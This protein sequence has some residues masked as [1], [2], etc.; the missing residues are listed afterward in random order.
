MTSQEMLADRRRNMEEDYFRRQELESIARLR[1][2]AAR[3][4]ERRK[5]GEQLDLSDDEML[6][7]LQQ[8]G[9]TS[10]TSALLFLAPLVQVAWAEGRVSSSERELILE[11]AA[12]Q[13]IGPG[14]EAYL[15]LLEW[16]SERPS[17]ELME[18]SLRLIGRMLHQMSPDER[19][20]RKY[21]LLLFAT[22]VAEASGGVMG[23]VG[24]G[25]RICREEEA[26]LERIV[27]AIDE[28]PPVTVQG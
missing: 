7:A 6:L 9:Y 12:T 18:G 1:E 24:L 14:S 17:E 11:A 10:E 16:L 4:A 8:L 27:T 28:S 26:M 23:F 2:R 15:K 21:E 19:E 3:E 25:N 5:M 13:G 22:Q 20:S